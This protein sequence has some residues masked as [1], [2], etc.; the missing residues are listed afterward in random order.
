MKVITVEEHQARYLNDLLQAQKE[1][2]FREKDGMG[3]E[4]NAY[5]AKAAELQRI[6]L[7]SLAIKDAQ[8][9]QPADR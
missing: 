1:R 4:S 2:I 7:I 6:D 8:D 9:R 3:S 5:R